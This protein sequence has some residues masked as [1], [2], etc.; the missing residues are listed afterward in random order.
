[1]DIFMK[2]VAGIFFVQEYVK[3]DAAPDSYSKA[4]DV[5][6]RWEFMFEK[7]TYS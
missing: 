3:H 1:M 2:S 5:Y 6:E 4:N 7:G